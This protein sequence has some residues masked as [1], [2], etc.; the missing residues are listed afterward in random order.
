M[1]ARCSLVVNGKSVRVSTGDTPLEAALADGMIA[2]TPGAGGQGAGP[3]PRRAQSRA[4]RGEAIKLS[5]PRAAAIEPPSRLVLPSRP[6]AVQKRTGTV[7]EI[8]ALGP[9]TF[10]VVVTIT[11]RLALE[12]GHGLD[13]TF[14]NFAPVTLSPTLRVDGS[15]ELNELVFH[16][17]QDRDGFGLGHELVEALALRSPGEGERARSVAASTVP[18]ADASF[19]LLPRPASH[20]SGRSPMQRATSN[21]P[22]KSS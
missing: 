1:S 17:R 21:P 11:R 15:A 14:E 9:H 18:G 3:A 19:L 10:Q 4:H 2:A 7:T 22:V 20:R 8:T 5:L 6:T 16:L 12:P 13:V